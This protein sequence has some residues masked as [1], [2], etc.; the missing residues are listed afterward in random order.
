MPTTPLKPFGVLLN[1]AWALFR[2]RLKTLVILAVILAALGFISALLSLT[3]ILIPVPFIALVI[4][5]LVFSLAQIY[6]VSGEPKPVGQLLGQ[7]WKLWWPYL[8]TSLLAA[9]VIM[10]GFSILIIPGII[11]GV[12]LSFMMFVFAL[13]GLR[14]RAALRRSHS[15]VQ[16]AW[17]DVFWRMLVAG[18]MA[19]LALWVVGLIFGF[20][21][22]TIV[23]SLVYG[24]L[25]A[26]AG[27]WTLCFSY[28]V[29]LNAKERVGGQPAE[30]KGG[31]A[32]Y[33]VWAIIGVVGIIIIPIIWAALGFAALISARSAL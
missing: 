28:R 6:A 17:F 25:S 19:G 12:Y 29:Y 16:G 3:I 14:G 2:S 5:T 10:G 21:K 33:T 11:L 30:P 15:Y 7:A 26:L 9:L 24:L 32:N 18:L 8:W 31:W 1:E 4:V 27:A 13:E 20:L 23:W 22:D